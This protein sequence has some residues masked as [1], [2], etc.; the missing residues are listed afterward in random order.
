MS[1]AMS[2]GK[3]T[4]AERTDISQKWATTGW[5]KYFQVKRIETS[6][7]ELEDDDILIKRVDYTFQ[8]PL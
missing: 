5:K 3:R 1:S 8:K 2:S 4:P 6:V 7:E